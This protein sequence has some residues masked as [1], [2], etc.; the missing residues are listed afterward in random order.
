MP[1]VRPLASILRSLSFRA[2]ATFKIDE[3]GIRVTVEEG[4]SLQAHA[5]VAANAFSSYTFQLEADNPAAYVD[6]PR[7]QSDSPASSPAAANVPADE[8]AMTSPYC[9]MSVSLSTILECLNIFGNAGAA[10]SSSFKR[11]GAG[12]YDSDGGGGGDDAGG[13]SRWRGKRKRQGADDDDDDEDGG[14]GRYGRRG[15]KAQTA[16]EG[17][18]TSLQLSYTGVGEPLVMLLEESGIVTRCEITTY[19]PEGLL[20][21][22]FN[23]DDKVQRLIIKSDWLSDALLEVPSSSEK[24]SISF[25]PSDANEDR[26]RQRGRARP[27]KRERRDAGAGEGA[28]DREEDDE[29]EE[30]EEEEVPL[31]R[32][33]SVGPMG[34]TEMD[35]SDDKDV[36]EIFECE[37]ALRN[38]YKYS[39]IMLTKHALNVSI[40][41]SIRTDTHG[42]VS[43][44]FMIPMSTRGPK[45]SMKEGKIGFVEFLCVALDEEY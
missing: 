23:D 30:E 38:S 26:Y 5:Y 18:T 42:L 12:G 32:L 1:D 41:T 35:Y 24:L 45:V 21:L 4:R 9:Q 6:A 31:F 29:E 43:F 44:Q 13:G 7:N 25:S 34:S 17:K 20:D 37:Q 27:R 28:S 22:A 11:E 19:V 8:D 10:A 2:Q 40:K 39:H 33:E 15:G 3:A 14:Y 16:D 36:L